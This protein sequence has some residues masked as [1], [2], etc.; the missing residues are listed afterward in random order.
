MKPNN[1]PLFALSLRFSVHLSHNLGI[2]SR[3]KRLVNKALFV[4]LSCPMQKG[5]SRKNLGHA[6][7]KLG[8]QLLILESIPE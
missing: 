8:N 4:L 6:S 2:V 1:F 3:L 7:M 5:P